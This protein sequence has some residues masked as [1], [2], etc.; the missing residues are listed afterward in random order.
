MRRLM[1]LF[2]LLMAT[3]LTA[4]LALAQDTTPV[5]SPDAGCDP[6]PEEENEATAMRW[7]DEVL[8]RGDLGVIDD[9]IAADA[10][11]EGPTIF[12]ASRNAEETKQILASIRI[13]YPDIQYTVDD[14]ISSEDLVVIRWTAT[15]IH[16]AEFHGMPASGEQET[17]TG[18]N[19]FQVACGQIVQS[20][21]AVDGLSQFDQGSPSDISA[22]P[23]A[24]P[25]VLAGECL[26][27]APEE[28]TAVALNYLDV[29]NSHDVRLFDDI[30]HPNIVH[31]WGHGED[32][33]GTDA[34]KTKM[35]TFITAFPD[36]AISF[37]EVIVEDDYVV[38]RWTVTGTQTGQFL[39]LEPSGVEVTWT[40]ININ[41]I[42]CGQVVESWSEADGLGIR[43]QL[44]NPENVAT[45]AS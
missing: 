7:F 16:E 31:H 8:N 29:W 45:P 41:R 44:Q 14:I 27:G 35:G 21:A 39:E 38:I 6:V 9:I 42:S 2:A 15:G 24:T 1:L 3:G 34:L 12:P 10:D 43:E 25:A 37:D 17:W 30:T 26:D 28:N 5:A 23:A 32:T 18:I 22:T 4:T 33:I 11:H 19:I 36:M 20:W 13:A 40:G